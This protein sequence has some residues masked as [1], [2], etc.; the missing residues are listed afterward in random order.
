MVIFQIFYLLMRSLLM[1]QATLTAENF[2]LRQQLAVY[3]RTVR[4]PQLRSSDRFF[5]VVFSRVW[6]DW[7]EVLV[8]VKPETVVKWHRQG[9]ALYW[10]WKSKARLCG[11]PQ[12]EQEIRDLIRRM[13][14]EN[15][16]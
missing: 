8:I 2:A 3:Q 16:L 14:R 11:R 15:L 10:R 13:S 9:C 12:I 1:S 7:R 5:W 6:K 4:R